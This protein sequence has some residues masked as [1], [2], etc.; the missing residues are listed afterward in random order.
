M[1][2]NALFQE[3][4]GHSGSEAGLAGR[5]RVPRPSPLCI[6]A[7]FLREFTPDIL[8]RFLVTCSRIS[9]LCAQ[10]AIRARRGVPRGGGVFFPRVLVE[11]GG[12]RGRC[13]WSIHGLRGLRRTEETARS[14]RATAGGLMR[15]VNMRRRLFA[16]RAGTARRVPCSSK[17]S[18]EEPTPRSQGPDHRRGRRR[19]MMSDHSR[20]VIAP[21]VNGVS[22]QEGQGCGVFG[23]PIALI[24]P[25]LQFPGHGAGA[26]CAATGALDIVRRWIPAR[27]TPGSVPPSARMRPRG[28]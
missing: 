20:K 9:R 26:G 11:V 17:A 22:L 13:A 10:G 12:P 1:E 3:L 8:R 24:P 19:I 23:V 25:G 6:L 21:L 4:R 18:L 16:A 7:R 27:I 2:G 15:L 28:R 14:R 5:W